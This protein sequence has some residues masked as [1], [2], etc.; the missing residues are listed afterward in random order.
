[1]CY[2]RH[3]RGPVPS[4]QCDEILDLRRTALLLESGG[5]QVAGQTVPELAV[6][7]VDRRTRGGFGEVRPP[8]DLVVACAGQVEAE[9]QSVGGTRVDPTDAFDEEAPGPGAPGPVLGALARVAL[10]GE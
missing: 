9:G 3:S 1:M 6:E 8:E 10:G 4:Q 5:G 2:L 7:A